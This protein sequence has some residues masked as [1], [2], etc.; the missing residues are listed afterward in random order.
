VPGEFEKLPRMEGTVDMVA[1][2]E[3]KVVR[4]V[5]PASGE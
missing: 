4:I 2:E 1:P 5:P 3:Y